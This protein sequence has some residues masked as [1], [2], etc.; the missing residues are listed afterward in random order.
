M[1]IIRFFWTGL[2]L[3]HLVRMLAHK[4]SVQ[5]TLPNVLKAIYNF[6]EHYNAIMTLLVALIRRYYNRAYCMEYRKRVYNYIY[7]KW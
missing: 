7:N 3:S 6:T 1:I 4:K 2:N 5:L